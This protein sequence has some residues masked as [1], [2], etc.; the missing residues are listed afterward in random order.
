MRVLVTGGAGY[1]GS[2]TAKELARSGHEPIVLDDLSAGHRWA[3]KWGPL[4]QG[5][6]ADQELVSRTLR[7]FAVE[8]VIHFAAD[9]KVG[10]SVEQPRKYYWHN[11]VNSLKLVD[12]MLDAGVKTI[13][14][15][16]SAA[17]YGVP[18]ESPI[19]EDHAKLP[20][21]P[22]GE[23]KL[24]TERMLANYATAYGLRWMALRYFNA[25]GADPEGEIGEDHA[26]ESHMIPSAIEAALGQR[27]YVEIFGTDYPTPDGTAIRDY[28]HV[29]DLGRA[30]VRALEHLASGGESTAVNLGTGRGNSVREV[31]A[32]VQQM[33]GGSMTVREGPRRAGDPPVLVAAVK[34]AGSLLGWTA[35]YREI[36]AIVGTAWKWHVSHKTS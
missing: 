11:V 33:C 17:T 1:I 5:D 3:V 13:V 2:H 34:K 32:A 23:T 35:E 10:E 14:F 19:P 4:A 12:A 15:S 30:H 25:C 26:P 18:T 31:I 21:N 28:I 24:T 6:L 29:T 7:D 8:A 9:A 36:G 20:V 16:S 27:P 22:Y